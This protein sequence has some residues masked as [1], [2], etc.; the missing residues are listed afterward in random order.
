VM[1]DASKKPRH[2]RWAWAGLGMVALVIAA[3]VVLFLTGGGGS[4][5]GTAT[6]SIPANSVPAASQRV[7][8][9]GPTGAALPAA[10]SAALAQVRRESGEPLLEGGKPLVF[11]MGAEWCPFCAS[12]RWA[13]VKATSRFGKWS[14]LGELLSR[15]GQDYFPPL[16]TYD[17]TRAT[18]TSPYIK[19]RHKELATVSGEPLQKLDSFEEGLVD[20]YDTRGSVPFLFASGADGRYTVELGFSPTLLEGRDYA[21]LHREVATGAPTPGVEAI[22]GQTEAITA[23]I[24]KLDRQ[25]PA[26]VCAKGS[27]PALEAA[28]E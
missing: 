25:Q 10:D 16:P 19:L 15:S 11:F 6:G 7:S 27:I 12:E 20:E 14:G 23:L 2:S 24:C 18:Y 9:A 26:S 13:L 4:D 22:D 1:D 28:L 3:V 8:G 17:L 21:E 5:G